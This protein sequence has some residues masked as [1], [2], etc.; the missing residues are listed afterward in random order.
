MAS[1]AQVL[2]LDSH[3]KESKESQ[4]LNNTQWWVTDY[5]QM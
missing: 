1:R 5:S 4:E 3:N 2:N